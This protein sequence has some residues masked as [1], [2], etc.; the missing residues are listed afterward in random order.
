MKPELMHSTYFGKNGIKFYDKNGIG[1]YAI[2]EDAL[3]Q[4][5]EDKI[6]DNLDY[7]EALVVLRKIK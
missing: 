6:I 5:Y 4:F 2:G 7:I 1:F 3:K